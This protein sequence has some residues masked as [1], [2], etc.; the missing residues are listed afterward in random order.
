MKR[1]KFSRSHYNLLTCNMG[2]LVPI[3]WDE[4]I[5]GDIWQMRTSALIRVSPQVK[6]TMH[7]VRVRV[8]HWFCP[9]RLIWDDYEDF[10]TGG[11][12]GDQ[13]PLHPYT[14]HVGTLNSGTIWDYLGVP[15]GSYGAA[16]NVN[17]LPLRA[18]NKIYNEHYRDQDLI[19]EV[20]ISTSGGGISD[21]TTAQALQFVAWEKDRFTTCRSTPQ[22]GSDIGIPLS[23]SGN[24]P[25]FADHVGVER[26][27]M[28]A[29]ATTNTSWSSAGT[30]ATQAR[31]GD[32][33]LAVSLE[34]LRLTIG[35][36]RYMEIMNRAGARYGEY[37][38]AIFGVNNPD[39]RLQ[40]PEYLGG[41]RQ[42]IAFSEILATA[43]GTSTEVGDL[44]GHGI[45]AMRTRR[46]RRFFQEHGIVMTLLSVVPRAIYT[47]AIDRALIRDNQTVKE[48][49]FV[50]QL[51]GIGDD[52][53]TN[54]EAYAF[55][56]TPD[57]VFGYQNRYEE[58]RTKESRVS[59][60]MKESPGYNW[61]MG[62]VHGGDI[63][64][65][66]SWLECNP[67]KRIL[68]DQVADSL[69]IMA[70]HSIQTRRPIGRTGMPSKI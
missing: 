44:K 1:N 46:F 18:Y 28:T 60:E 39:S 58:Y 11:Q 50:P 10:F 67:T 56:S 23:P 12:D 19:P 20:D 69:Q 62:R 40:I 16:K 9:Y 64:L 29:S 70:S 37:A 22:R 61:H 8:H 38:R 52:E 21:T 4:V 33:A 13:T 49:Y 15:V 43:E 14:Q 34:D 41:G 27:L 53:I 26:A 57:G 25:T 24:W 65:N 17:V 45:A 63:A 3:Y 55:H 68:A 2:E 30:A 51:Q 32:P 59:G 35:K 48:D 54:R 6:P 7:P 5:P 31:W 36:Q 47:Q 66:Q 42:T